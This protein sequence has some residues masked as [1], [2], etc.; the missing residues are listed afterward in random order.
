MAKSVGFINPGNY[1]TGWAEDVQVENSFANIPAIGFGPLGPGTLFGSGITVGP[2]SVQIETALPSS[3]GSLVVRITDLNNSNYQQVTIA[4]GSLY[5]YS[6]G[7]PF[8]VSQGDTLVIQTQVSGDPIVIPKL[9][10]S[11]VQM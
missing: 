1:I 11:T 3:C 10:W 4:S 9:Q 7:S 5:G 8:S 6:G 2:L